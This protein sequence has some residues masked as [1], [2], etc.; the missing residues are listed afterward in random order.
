VLEPKGN[1]VIACVSWRPDG[2]QLVSSQARDATSWDAASGQIVEELSGLGVGSV[3]VSGLTQWNPKGR[4]IASRR[5]GDDVTVH[6]L[7]AGTNRTIAPHTTRATTVAFAARGRNLWVGFADGSL[8]RWDLATGRVA[9]RLVVD[10]KALTSI[11]PALDEGLLVVHARWSSLASIDRRTGVRRILVG[12][13]EDD[14]AEGA[15]VS[16]DGRL[17]A[18]TGPG[19][20]LRV[21]DLES[22]AVRVL[23][24]H[25]ER[26][27][28]V[29]W[30]SDGGTI[31]TASETVRAWD[32][33]TGEWS[34][35][36]LGGN[37]A[38]RI[39]ASPTEPLL[40][41]AMSEHVVLMRGPTL[42]QVG[43]LSVEDGS[44]TSLAFSPGGRVLAYG[45]AGGALH[46]HSIGSNDLRCVGRA[47]ARAVESI[48]FSPGG[49]SVA[50][51][52]GDGT[53]RLWDASTL[54]ARFALR[55]VE[56]DSSYV[57]TEGAD[58]RVEVFGDAA[59]IFVQAAF[60]HRLVPI[61][62][63]A[64]LIVEGLAARARGR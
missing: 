64:E 6:D 57:F 60:G 27:G 34:D 24:S 10:G 41:V 56:G 18:S 23:G 17:L 36:P 11:L 32:L 28:C 42:E 37:L 14:G 62:E 13:D 16:P 44:V 30:S 25:D 50:T 46:L 19:R 38:S 7:E 58:A 26:L 61:D 45:S 29:A 15:A 9:E 21:W 55:A 1:S 43:K 63:A 3:G 33:A 40:A 2:R 35:A 53:I 5:G 4:W 52:D 22:G 47:H 39:A 12:R 8:L 49:E 51:A 31:Y 59:R 48:A 20:S 54:E